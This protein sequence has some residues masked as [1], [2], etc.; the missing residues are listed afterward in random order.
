MLMV[1]GG[2]P[3]SQL[4]AWHH[5]APARQVLGKQHPASKRPDTEP[6]RQALAAKLCHAGL[7]GPPPL[8]GVPRA[9]TAVML[10]VT[11]NAYPPGP[12][13]FKV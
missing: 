4:R 13:G 8:A 9:A 6:Q 2:A 10:G 11:G 7:Q 1:P 12:S 5:Q 3:N